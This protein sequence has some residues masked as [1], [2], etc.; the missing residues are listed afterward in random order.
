MSNDIAI[1]IRRVGATGFD[2]NIRVDENPALQDDAMEKLDTL[3]LTTENEAW[4]ISVFPWHIAYNVGVS[5]RYASGE[6]KS[7]DTTLNNW[8]KACN[9]KYGK[10]LRIEK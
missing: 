4:L 7:L 8:L 9:Q 3:L 1:S 10:N 5:Y 6:V 2:I